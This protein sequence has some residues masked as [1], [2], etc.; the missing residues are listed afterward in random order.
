MMIYTVSEMVAEFQDIVVQL[1]TEEFQ[2]SPYLHQNI[3]PIFVYLRAIQ[4][5]VGM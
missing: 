4:S 5:V 3:N 1:F 2:I